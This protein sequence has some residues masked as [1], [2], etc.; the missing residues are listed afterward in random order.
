MKA[1]AVKICALVAALT[2]LAAAQDLSPSILGARPPFLLVLGCICGVPAAVCAGLFA[3][4]LGGFPFGC[5][6]AFFAIAAAL[7]RMFRPAAFPVAVAAAGLYQV[8]ILL[9]GG[10]VPA[11]PA[12]YSAAL[13]AALLYPAMMAAA[14]VVR[15]HAGIDAE[16]GGAS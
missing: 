6:A 10:A 9:W 1:E 3:D 8:W 7:A 13:I 4:A 16:P 12:A 15:L 11:T 14:A 5:S 2:V